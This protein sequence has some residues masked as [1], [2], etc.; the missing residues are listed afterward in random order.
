MV[1]KGH[2]QR[3]SILKTYEERVDPFGEYSP[4]E[5]RARAE[6][7][8]REVASKAGKRSGES[9]RKRAARLKELEDALGAA[10]DTGETTA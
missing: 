9:R 6:Q 8:M 7:Y 4:E 1:P 10:T 3:E 5:R 2:S